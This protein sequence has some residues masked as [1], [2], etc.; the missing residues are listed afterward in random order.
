M[1]QICVTM[2][3]C[4]VL[5]GLIIGAFIIGIMGKSDNYTRKKK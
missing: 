4:S 1:T 3:F 5:N 2:I